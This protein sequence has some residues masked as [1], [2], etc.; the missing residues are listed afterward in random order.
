MVTEEEVLK[1]GR[2]LEKAS[3]DASVNALDI[4]QALEASKITLD[5]LTRTKIGVIVNNFRKSA[6]STPETVSL[7]KQLIK[8]WKK[9]LPADGSKAPADNKKSETKTEEPTRSAL[10]SHSL[11]PM[12]KDPVRSKCAQMLETSLL[13]DANLPEGS[14]TPAII[15][16]SIE[17]EI[18]KEFKSTDSKYKN[19]V[20]SRVSNLRDKN[21][22]HLRINVLLGSITP[23]KLVKMTP[24]EMASD[25][26]KK[27]RD[28]FN[29]AAINDA[30]L[31]VSSGTT[32][33]LLK[34]GKCGKRNCTY[35]QVQ[36]RSADEP[37]TTFCFCNECGHRWKFC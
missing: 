11:P 29:K 4:L 35:N 2:K 23:E 21:N 3:K 5:V 1:F 33:D 12:G 10:P 8:N 14:G 34:C 15:A 32:T 22:P 37:M 18:Y 24:E 26:M 20:R 19:K 28:E 7:S 30:Q 16:V 13:G 9:L 27:K 6:N 25:E 17:E 36:T 31:A